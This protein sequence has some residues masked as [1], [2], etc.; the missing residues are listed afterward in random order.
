MRVLVVTSQNIEERGNTYWCA[1]NVYDI[2]RRFMRLGELSLCAIRYDANKSH[3]R[4]ERDLTGVVAFGHVTYIHKARLWLSKQD[5]DVI[6]KSVS[7]VDLVISYGASYEVFRIARNHGKKFMSFVVSCAWDAYWNHGW[8]GKLVAPYKFLRARYT[9]WHS[10]YVLY[11]TNQFLQRRYPTQAKYQCGCSN[12]RITALNEAILSKRLDFIRQ[13]DGRSLRIATTAA[14]DVRYKGQ[15]YVLNALSNLKLQGYTDIHYYL[16]GGGS[17]D[18]L[19]GLVKDYGLERQ[20]HFLGMRPHDEVFSVLDTMHVYIQPSLQEGLPR[21]MV[22]AMSRGLMCIGAK[23][24]A[25]PELIEPRFVTRR[26]SAA[27]I[28]RLLTSV[29]REQLAEQAQRNF[30]EAHNYAETVL[31]SRRD[32]FFDKVKIDIETAK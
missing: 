15:Q 21:A 18:Y 17:R 22:E 11:V 16:I 2:L 27:D 5:R 10:D 28:V 8:L 32:E 7:Q 9:I 31:N 4:M 3:L 23:T 26:K 20:V 19:E 13:W 6:S 14:V 12:V 29:S 1:S 25:I 30:R 24:A